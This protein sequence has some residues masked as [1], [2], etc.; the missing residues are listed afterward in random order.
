[1]MLPSCVDPADAAPPASCSLNRSWFARS[2]ACSISAISLQAPSAALAFRQPSVDACWRRWRCA[3]AQPAKIF[4]FRIRLELS[5][6]QQPLSDISASVREDPIFGHCEVSAH[7]VDGA[8]RTTGDTARSPS[9]G[10][11]TAPTPDRKIHRSIAPHQANCRRTLHG[12]S[13]VVGAVGSARPSLRS[14]ASAST[15]D[16]RIDRGPAWIFARAGKTIR[17]WRC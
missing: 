1:M 3:A 6:F 8:R 4:R 13:N 14:A 2:A 10:E 15:S 5:P 11:D 16:G 9:S 7:D 17:W 12:D